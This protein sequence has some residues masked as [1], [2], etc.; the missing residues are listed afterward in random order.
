MHRTFR[1]ANQLDCKITPAGHASGTPAKAATN[2]KI[3]TEDGLPMDSI[4]SV[5]LD[6]FSYVE[7]YSTTGDT[8]GY[9]IT[10]SEC[11]R[12][13]TYYAERGV[14]KRNQ[15]TASVVGTWLTAELEEPS[16]E[17]VT[18]T[19]EDDFDLIKFG[20][21]PGPSNWILKLGE[22]GL[23]EYSTNL[24][25]ITL[26]A[27]TSYNMKRRGD[28]RNDLA[29][30][31][32]S[33][34]DSCDEGTGPLT[35]TVPQYPGHRQ[36]GVVVQDALG[37]SAQG[38]EYRDVPVQEGLGGLGRV[39]LDEAS[40][41]VGQVQDEAVGFLF[42]PVDDHQ[43]L[44]KVAL[45]VARRMGQGHKHLLRPAALLPHV[46]LDCGVLAAEPMLVP[47]SLE[48][49]LGCAALLPGTPEVVR[50][51]LVYDAGEGLL[52]SLSKG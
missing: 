10:A 32:V 26:N 36:I 42:H 17:A 3:K 24:H 30:F 8:G 51:D 40:V 20:R 16:N 35:T 4:D 5:T 9:Q 27:G 6:S 15:P 1:T 39:S 48:D 45:G 34:N 52:L 21:E 14:V 31:I 18:V 7:V 13:T 22:E 11:V 12:N 2:L 38:G 25:K 37:R 49:P 29:I 28:L 47:E 41:A 46:V 23:V 19:A 50:Q 43:G 33:A 44:A